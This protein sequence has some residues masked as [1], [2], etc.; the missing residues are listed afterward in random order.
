M[1]VVPLHDAFAGHALHDEELPPP[2][3][4]FDAHAVHVVTV[5]PDE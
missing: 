1:N 3:Y 2:P 5:P 4:V